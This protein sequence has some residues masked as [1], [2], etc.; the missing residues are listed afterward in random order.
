MAAAPPPSGDATVTAARIPLRD[1]LLDL[2]RTERQFLLFIGLA[3]IVAGAATPYPDIARWVGFLLATYSTIAN[4]SI[5]TVGTFIASNEHRPWW[6]LWLFIGGVFLAT[7]AYAWAVA[8][9]VGDVSFGR[10]QTPAYS[11]TPTSFNFFQVAAPIFL[12]I[13]TRF[14]MPVSTTFL[15]LTCF[16]SEVKGVT[17]VLMKSVAGYGVAFLLGGLVFAVTARLFV[18]YRDSKPSRWWVPAQWIS[19]AILW[20]SWVMQDTANLAIYLPRALSFTQYLIFSASFFFGLGV[21]F[22][23]RGDKIQRVVTEKSSVVDIRAATLVDFVYGFILFGFVQIST[24]PMSTTWVF[25][26][27]LAGRELALIAMRATGRPI[28]EGLRLVG[29]DLLYVAIG[30]LVSIAIAFIANPVFRAMIVGLFGG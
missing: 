5:Q 10:L 28:G 30:L 19:T 8:D 4:D 18:R 23:L 15:I 13:L 6:L 12:M 29:R 11:T 21:L 27:L 20:S 14:R 25:I 7:I 2:F 22:Y 24:I 9:P 26:G 1:T 3:L 16:A 17:D